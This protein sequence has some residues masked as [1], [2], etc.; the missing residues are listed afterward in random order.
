MSGT[1]FLTSMF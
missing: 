1:E